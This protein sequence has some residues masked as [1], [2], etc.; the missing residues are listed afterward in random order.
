MIPTRDQL[1]HAIDA[2]WAPAEFI[3][4]GPVTLRRGLGGGSRVSAAT[5]DGDWA[6]DDLTRAETAMRDMGQTPQYMVRSG[7]NALD[8]AL[9]ARGY[10][11]KDPVQI[12]TCPISQ[13]T[14]RDLPRVMIFNLWEP[15]A[16]Q[17]EIWAE[18]GIGPARIDVM[19]RVTGPKTALMARSS[20]QPAGVGFAA[21]DGEIAMV[22]AVE[23]RPD[24][25]R[26]GVASWMMRGAALWAA[27]QGAKHM[28]VLCT[29]ANIG[30]N[31]LYSSLGME[32]QGGYHYRIKSDA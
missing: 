1:L 17:R 32:P 5:V 26:R 31:A 3:T 16:I 8:D 25:R 29:R 24:H 28:A 20:E 11:I 14:D 6:N 21:V 13:L 7:E 4:C 22:H 27:K 15:L 18:G 23:I 10:E 2:T 9:A 19:R 30:A 12:L